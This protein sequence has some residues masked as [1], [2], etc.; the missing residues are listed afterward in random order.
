MAVEQKFI[1]EPSYTINNSDIN[2]VGELLG[3]DWNVVCDACQEEELYGQDGSGSCKATR[4][5]RF[6]ND[7]ITAIFEKIFEDNPNAERITIIDDF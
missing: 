3:F 6:E 5:E 1:I 7:M 2:V 4:G